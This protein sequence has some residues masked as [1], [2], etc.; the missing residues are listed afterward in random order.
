MAETARTVLVWAL[1]LQAVAVLCVDFWMSFTFGN[2]EGAGEP[3]MLLVGGLVRGL[4]FPLALLA[5]AE[6]IEL[7]RRQR[8]R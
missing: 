2:P 5:F 7:L 4:T 3:P 1:R 6:I 8:T